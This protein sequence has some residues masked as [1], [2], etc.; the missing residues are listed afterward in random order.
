MAAV[1]SSTS[2]CVELE[3]EPK[4]GPTA[5]SGKR[6]TPA[7]EGPGPELLGV[8][9]V[10]S[11]DSEDSE[12]SGLEDSGSDSDSDEEEEEEEEEHEDDGSDEDQEDKQEDDKAQ[13]A[14]ENHTQVQMEKLKMDEYEHDSSDEEVR[15][16]W[17]LC[18]L[19]WSRLDPHPHRF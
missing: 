6:R 17:R 1:M 12:F 14:V 4:S 10:D 2:A 9:P 11:S 18:A 16:L 5:G 15:T 8:G 13:G 19:T 7:E 3:P